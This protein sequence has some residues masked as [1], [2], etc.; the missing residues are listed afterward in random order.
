MSLQ[1]WACSILYMGGM[2]YHCYQKLSNKYLLFSVRKKMKLLSISEIFAQQRRHIG[3]HVCGS[4]WAFNQKLP[5]A[6]STFVT[7]FWFCIMKVWYKIVWHVTKGVACMLSVLM[8]ICK[9]TDSSLSHCTNET[10]KCN[11]GH[12][13]WGS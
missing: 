8:H 2:A 11:Y 5:L 3:I 13:G 6:D 10:V 12:D 9:L 4:C 1:F 7:V